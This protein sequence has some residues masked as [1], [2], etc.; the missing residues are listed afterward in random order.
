MKTN[1]LTDDE[2]LEMLRLKA[3]QLKRTPRQDEFQQKQAIVS[4]FGSWNKGVLKSGLHLNKVCNLNKE[5]ISTLIKEWVNKYE[6]I[7]TIREWD[8]AKA[9]GENI[10]SALT[11]M[12]KFNAT[13][14]EVLKIVILETKTE[15]EKCIDYKDKELL[16]ML[17]KELE[18]LKT[19]SIRVYEKN[20]DRNLPSART[21]QAR[22]HCSWQ[23]LI[24]LTGCS[25]K[26]KY[27][28]MSRTE[29]LDTL[30]DLKEKLGYMPSFKELKIYGYDENVF[31]DKFVS[32][33]NVILAMESRIKKNTVKESKEQLLQMYINFCEKIGNLA[34]AKDLNGSDNIYNANV[35]KVQFDGMENLK[36][37]A[38]EFLIENKSIKFKK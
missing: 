8:N 5:Q 26:K 32:Y 34:T 10:P 21:Y 29:L 11:V 18:R 23:D 36:K 14:N 12:N 15:S 38:K 27:S 4:Y 37:I 6:K 25:V 20:R 24:Q 17:K 13:W 28:E 16:N 2:L 3:K 19:I 1:N 22:F 35:F 33:D 9:K 30:I 7:P 31:I